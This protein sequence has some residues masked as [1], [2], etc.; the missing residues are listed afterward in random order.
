[1]SGERF[2]FEYE[3]RDFSYLKSLNIKNEIS[4]EVK[5]YI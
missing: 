5:R 2:D 3:N 4:E 1:M